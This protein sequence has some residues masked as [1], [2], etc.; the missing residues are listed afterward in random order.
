LL[1]Q[2][3]D[4]N[5]VASD[6]TTALHWAV[7]HDDLELVDRFI[8]A[9]ADV[10]AANDYGST[11][12]SEAGVTGNAAII[13]KLLEAGADVEAVNEDGQTVLMVVARSS[14]VAAAKV[15]LDHGASVNG[16]EE[17]RGQTAL[18]WAA[19]QSQPEMVDLLVSYGAD[20]DARSKVNRWERLVSAE[21]RAHYRPPGGWTALL[22]AAR[23]GC[24]DCARVLVEAGADLDM[25]DPEGATPM[26]FA[27]INWHFDLARFLLESGANP[28]KWDWWGRTPLYAAVDMNTLPEGGWPDRPPLDQTTSLQLI[29][30]LLAAGANPD[31]R[32]KLYPV[33][34][35]VQHDRGRFLMMTTGATSMLRAAQALDAVAVRLLLEHGADPNLGNAVGVT[36]RQIVGITPL[37]A[38]AGLEFRRRD[39][40]DAYPS[41]DVEERSI[42][43]LALLLA[44]GAGVN[45]RDSHGRTALHGA[46][47]LGRTRVVEFLADNNAAPLAADADG[48]TPLDAALGRML[49]GQA[50]HEETAAFLRQL[51]SDGSVGARR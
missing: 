4:I 35:S 44:G 3:A 27:I 9:G 40:R 49:G 34:R 6:G 20:I 24:L 19:A 14:N 2:G 16:T 30:L 31:A 38:A 7:Y 51:T 8:D 48:M 22:F 43:V 50:V 32:L 28:D 17:W 23:Q 26:L 46:A 18:M 11:P 41:R 1:D 15:L 36:T 37:M 47:S 5:V 29:E 33:H 12:M 10:N 45:A 21:P 25:A 39:V 13:E 42:E